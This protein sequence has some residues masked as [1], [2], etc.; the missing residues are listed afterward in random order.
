V[1]QPTT[2][3]N[4]QLSAPGASA[5][6]WDDARGALET[7]ELFWIATVR[8]D[9]RPHMTPLVAIWLDDALHFCTGDTEQK[10]ANL[11]RNQNVI[12]VTGCN[13]WDDGMD[14][15]VEG[16]A[17]RVTDQ[18]TLG[19]LAQAWA[20]KWDGRWTYEPGPEGFQTDGNESIWVFAVRP[21]KVFALAKGN[22][23]HTRYTFQ[24]RD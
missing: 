6:S 11:R 10:A 5:T 4:A 22:F 9:G 2:T 15:I 21:R 7:A 18:R 17:A 16:R 1:T 13:Q 8:T 23:S 19:R 20:G 24:G 3:L 14:V 12:L